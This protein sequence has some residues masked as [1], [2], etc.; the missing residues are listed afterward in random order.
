MR[1]YCRAAEEGKVAF[2]QDD[3][4]ELSR[5]IPCI[6]KVAPNTKDYFIEDVHRAG[7]IPA[8]LGELN[9]SGLLDPDVHSIHHDSL[10]GYLD[11]WDVRGGKALPEAERLFHAAPGGV[12]TTEMFSATALYKEL[13]VDAE[14]GC[15][16]DTEH[17]YTA[18]GGLGILKGNIAIDGCV[19]KT[20]GVP[21]DQ[22]VFRG[23]AKVTESQ[24]T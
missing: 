18:D 5:R 10:Q 22:W 2:T 23:P 15:I 8:I 20:A 16:R 11:D 24:D 9:R 12:R 4:D 1:P 17:A 13:D 21:A 19:V 3:I 6:C 14:N 7:G